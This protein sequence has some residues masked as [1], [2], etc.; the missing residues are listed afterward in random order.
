M[1]TYQ[2]N[3]SLNDNLKKNFLLSHE[4][5]NKADETGKLLGLNFSQIVRTALEEFIKRTEKE[6]LEKE[7]IEACKFY[8]SIDTKIAKDWQETEGQI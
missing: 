2:S 7:M 4:L 1:K 8:N 5:A 3:T 6:K